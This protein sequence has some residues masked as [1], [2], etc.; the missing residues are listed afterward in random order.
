MLD[1]CIEDQVAR[2]CG[3]DDNNLR[4]PKDIVECGCMGEDGLGVKVYREV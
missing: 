2:G 1:I 4:F 3:G